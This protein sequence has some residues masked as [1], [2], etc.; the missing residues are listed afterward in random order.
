VWKTASDRGR[1]LLNRLAT[2]RRRN[3]SPEVSDLYRL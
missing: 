2:L 3:K 1:V